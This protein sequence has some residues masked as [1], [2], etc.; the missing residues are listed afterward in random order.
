MPAK[1]IFRIAAKVLNEKEKKFIKVR[2]FGKKKRSLREL[3]DYIGR[4]H[5]TVFKDEA[6]ILKKIDKLYDKGV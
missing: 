2:Y 4:D 5:V 3:A 6:K 1:K